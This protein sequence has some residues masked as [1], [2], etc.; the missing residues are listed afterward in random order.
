MRAEVV[1]SAEVGV[2]LVPRQ[3]NAVLPEHDVQSDNRLWTSCGGDASRRGGRLRRNRYRHS[4]SSDADV[5]RPERRA[6]RERRPGW[7][8]L[9]VY[10]IDGGAVS[11]LWPVSVHIDNSG[12]IPIPAALS[13]PRVCSSPYPIQ[14]HP[15]ERATV[16]RSP[17]LRGAASWSLRRLAVE[18]SDDT[19]EWDSRRPKGSN[20][21]SRC[22]VSA[23]H[24]H[25]S[26][27]GQ[28]AV[29]IAV[30]HP[31][32]EG[33]SE[34]IPAASSIMRWMVKGPQTAPSALCGGCRCSSDVEL[35]VQNKPQRL[36]QMLELEQ[37]SQGIERRVGIE[38]AAN[39]AGF[40]ERGH[41]G[42]TAHN[43][44]R[45]RRAAPG[46]CSTHRNRHPYGAS[47]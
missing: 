45:H 26:R 7:A 39:S 24:L 13:T 36:T 37:A 18:R 3:G 43:A 25:G 38:P 29:G 33:R 46:R 23:A 27:T 1:G 17:Q 14:I 32:D 8:L 9:P 6:H 4:E 22:T 20:T 10:E 15:P 40:G 12:V 5:R 2:V 19:P 11:L 34:R 47:V 21:V 42:V 30:H 16:P 31:P 44:P 41:R 28:A 35:G